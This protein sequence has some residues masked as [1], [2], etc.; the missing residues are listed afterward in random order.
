[1]SRLV[2]V[3]HGRPEVSEDT[4]PSTWSLRPEGV[5]AV[6]QLAA[7]IRLADP[8]TVLASTELKAVQTAEVLALGRVQQMAEFNEV[9]KPWFD[10]ASAH[11][12]ATG[13]YLAGEALAGW[14]P[15]TGATERFQRGIERAADGHDLVVVTHGTVMTAWLATVV[16]VADPTEFWSRLGQPD[17]WEVDLADRSIRSLIAHESEP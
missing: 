13:R 16:T 8:V 2:L 15:L 14:E 7:S 3:R 1:M 12:H 11:V 17:A 4:A 10:D 5:P 6:R 9:A